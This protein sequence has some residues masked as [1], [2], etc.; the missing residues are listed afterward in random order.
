[1]ENEQIKQLKTILMDKKLWETTHLCL[2]MINSQR[3]VKGKLGHVVQIHVCRLPFNVNVMLNLSSVTKGN[4]DQD[5]S[6]ATLKREE[7]YDE[8][9][10]AKAS[11]IVTKDRERNWPIA[12]HAARPRLRSQKQ[13]RNAFRPQF[14]EMNQ[15][16][17]MHFC[18]VNE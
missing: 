15:N 5:Y 16:L 1:M 17:F 18:K 11:G 2:E 9:T 12:D 4:A 7:S 13:L 3:Q 14:S 6:F 8:L 10:F